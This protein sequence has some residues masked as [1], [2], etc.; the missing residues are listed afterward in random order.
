MPVKKV[1]AVIETETKTAEVK[2]TNGVTITLEGK[3]YFVRKPKG[4]DMVEIEKITAKEQSQFMQGLIIVSHLCEEL[5]TDYLL[6]LY[7]EDLNS[8]FDAFNELLPA[9][10]LPSS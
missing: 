7:V 4:R 8:V 6:D 10:A 9:N 1:E 3:P 5:E 2:K